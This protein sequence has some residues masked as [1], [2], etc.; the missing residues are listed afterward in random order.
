MA[1]NE[2]RDLNE[3]RQQAGKTAGRHR[4]CYFVNEK[5]IGTYRDILKAM[6]D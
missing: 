1:Q 6:K 5:E 4:K 3:T 2:G